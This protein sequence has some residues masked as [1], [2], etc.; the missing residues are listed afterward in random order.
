L[1]P[2]HERGAEATFKAEVAISAGAEVTG[3]RLE[4]LRARV[5]AREDSDARR[6][7]FQE[8][9]D[10]TEGRIAICEDALALHG[11][12]VQLFARGEGTDSA[13]SEAEVIGGVCSL[14]TVQ[15]RRPMEAEAARAALDCLAAMATLWFEVCAP[16]HS[17]RTGLILRRLPDGCSFA[18]EEQ[19]QLQIR[20]L[21]EERRLLQL[22]G[23]E[24]L[25]VTKSGCKQRLRRKTHAP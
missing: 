6:K 21:Q 13:A 10:G 14:G 2:R 3:C 18:C 17:Q 19:L 11:V 1:H 23:P 4:A 15:T 24:A 9:V 20:H 8:K 7:A 12:L 16:Q 22:K 5:R 25:P